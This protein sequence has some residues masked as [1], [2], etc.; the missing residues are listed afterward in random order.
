MGVHV[1]VPGGELEIC[2]GARRNHGHAALDVHGALQRGDRRG[3]HGRA[4]VNVAL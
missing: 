4:T 3:L 2:P 1:P